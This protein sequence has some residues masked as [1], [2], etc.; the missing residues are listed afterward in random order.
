V[1]PQVLSDLWPAVQAEFM[2]SHALVESVYELEPALA[3]LYADGTWDPALTEFAIER[4]GQ[5]T[6]F[7]ASLYLTA[8]R[9]SADIELSPWLGRRTAD[10]GTTSC[11]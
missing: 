8:W 1:E 10:G 4:Y 2:A 9:Q 7:L 3:A 11:S 6:Q 5:A